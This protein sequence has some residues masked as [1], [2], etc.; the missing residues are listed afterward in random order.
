MGEPTP[1]GAWPADQSAVEQ[2]GQLTILAGLL[3]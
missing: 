2:G 3:R 1:S